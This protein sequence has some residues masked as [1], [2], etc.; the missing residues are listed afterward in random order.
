MTRGS[1]EYME[2]GVNEVRELGHGRERAATKE[3]RKGESGAQFVWSGV[4]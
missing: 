1:Q 2:M 3:I 4:R